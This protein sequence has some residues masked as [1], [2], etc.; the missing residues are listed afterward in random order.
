MRQG[1]AGQWWCV[2]EVACD[3]RGDEADRRDPDAERERREDL[4][5]FHGGE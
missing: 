2:D 3:D 5:A 1:I 4:D